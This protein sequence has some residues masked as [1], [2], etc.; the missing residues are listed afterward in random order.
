MGVLVVTVK[1]CGGLGEV[2]RDGRIPGSY[3]NYENKVYK[4]LFLLTWQRKD[5]NTYETIKSNK[6]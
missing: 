6:L 1:T 2:V 3:V 4:G 5:S